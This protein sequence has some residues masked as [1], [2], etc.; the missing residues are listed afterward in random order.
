M[1]RRGSDAMKDLSIKAP[2]APRADLRIAIFRIALSLGVAI[3][4][5]WLL[6]SPRAYVQLAASLLLVGIVAAFTLKDIAAR[7]FKLWDIK[8]FV[9][10]QYG[11]FL[12]LGML[13]DLTDPAYQF[14][15][16]ALVISFLGLAGLLAG[17]HIVRPR[18]RSQ[19]TRLALYPTRTQLLGAALTLYV[20]GFFFLY[21][22]WRLYG[23][24]QS[25]S[26]QVLAPQG[27]A[28]LPLPMLHVWTQLVGPAAVITL[29]LLRRRELGGWTLPLAI[30][31][32]LTMVWYFV[33]GNR[34]NFLM[35]AVAWVIIWSA[36]PGARGSKKIGVKPIL[37]LSLAAAVILVLSVVRY[38]WNF[39][40]LSNLSTEDV[41][42]ELVGSLDMV[43]QIRRTVEFFPERMPFLK[44][45]SFYGVVAN[46]VPRIWW[47]DKPVGVGYLTSVAYYRNSK[48]TIALSL[49]GELY[50]NFGVVGSL[51]GMVAFGLL[52]GRIRRWYS[53]R[54][55]DPATTVIYVQLVFYMMFEVRGDILDATT[56][57]IYLVLPVVLVFSLMTTVNHLMAREGWQPFKRLAP[58]LPEP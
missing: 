38:D 45:Y 32:G 43:G 14:N 10:A 6:V 21:L 51:F 13:I 9:L 54:R 33:W 5:A 18:P 11:L 46:V 19:P 49:P 40:R 22:E 24:I 41:Q 28:T 50:A 15:K 55:S 42:G 52:V 56:P 29:V 30:P 39:S 36:I 57:I 53:A 58:A 20:V 34:S 48:S 47:P 16:K 37:G 17:F 3:L 4:L 8:Y 44:G 27:M 31:F 12:G 35:L 2:Q 25:Y 26:G 23:E 7:R 1:G